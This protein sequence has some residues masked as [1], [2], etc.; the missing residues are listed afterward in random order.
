MNSN[1]IVHGFHFPISVH[2]IL[3]CKVHIEVENIIDTNVFVICRKKPKKTW[4]LKKSYVICAPSGETMCKHIF[5]TKTMESHVYC[6]EAI[7]SNI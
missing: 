7:D 2:K 3:H 4:I 5:N 6:I 1:V